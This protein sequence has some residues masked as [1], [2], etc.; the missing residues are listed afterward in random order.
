M[1]RGGVS[2]FPFLRR[3]VRRPRPSAQMVRVCEL[4]D[5]MQRTITE[6]EERGCR[7]VG[8]VCEIPED[9]PDEDELPF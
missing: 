2:M 1:V 5:R 8:V 7:I 6:L 9:I 3:L 4:L